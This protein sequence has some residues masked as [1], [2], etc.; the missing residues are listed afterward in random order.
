MSDI[1]KTIGYL[2]LV[3]VIVAAVYFALVYFDVV[4]SPMPAAASVPVALDPPKKPIDPHAPTPN[5][6]VI[7][8]IDGCTKIPD[9]SKCEETNGDCM[10]D[11]DKCIVNPAAPACD[12]LGSVTSCEATTGRCAWVGDKCIVAAIPV[13]GAPLPPVELDKTIIIIAGSV[14]L[15]VVVVAGFVIYKREKR[16]L[17]QTEIEFKTMQS[18]AKAKIDRIL[19][20]SKAR[21]EKL[22]KDTQAARIKL[23]TA[24]N[25]ALNEANKATRLFKEKLE[26]TIHPSSD[27]PNKKGGKYDEIQV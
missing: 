1:P 2:I 22:A 5:P 18:N 23:T 10:W 17:S 24:R 6:P 3:A 26:P 4:P 11:I 8:V 21:L 13:S 16:V 15:L 20:D 19:E 12:I 14:L 9:K 27:V 7:I 25:D